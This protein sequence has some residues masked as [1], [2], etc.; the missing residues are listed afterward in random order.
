MLSLPIAVEK[1]QVIAAGEAKPSI[2]RQ[3]GQQRTDANGAKLYDVP[4]VFIGDSGA[5]PVN[6]R[7][8][9]KRDG[10]SRCR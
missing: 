4:V 9:R 6:V 5:M 3:T 1:L 8:P 10:V 2:D 7:I